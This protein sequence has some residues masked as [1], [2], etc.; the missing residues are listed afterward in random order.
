MFDPAQ[1]KVGS[2]FE[3]SL[4]QLLTMSGRCMPKRPCA[5]IITSDDRTIICGDKFGDVYA[6]PVVQSD[7][8]LSSSAQSSPVPPKPIVPAANKFTVHTKRNHQALMNQLKSTN[9]ASEKSAPTFEH[10]LLLGH[11]SMLTDVIH[12]VLTL[13]NTKRSYILSADRDEHIRVS[14]GIPQAH[15]IE[16]FCLGHQDFVT[17]LC[18]PRSRPHLLISGGGDGTIFLWDWLGGKILQTMSLDRWLPEFGMPVQEDGSTEGASSKLISE[19]N[20]RKL[21]VSGIWYM[22]ISLPDG[23]KETT[24]SDVLIVACEG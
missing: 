20:I 14:R 9:Q 15:I 10:K 4:L 6:L 7:S 5:L 13:G 22:C 18:T 11:V 8:S 17:K 24:Y 12:V 23:V 19:Q 2:A 21:V 1:S 16:N 3:M